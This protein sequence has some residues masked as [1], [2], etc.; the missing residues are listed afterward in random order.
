M[1]D[2]KSEYCHL[3]GGKNNFLTFW[4]AKQEKG[5]VAMEDKN[6]ERIRPCLFHKDGQCVEEDFS[7]CI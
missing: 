2:F 6:P 7:S 4:I 3:N 1:T 5:G